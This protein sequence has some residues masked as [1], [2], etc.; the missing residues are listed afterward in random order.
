MLV[1]SLRTA[2]WRSTL[3]IRLKNKPSSRLFS[4]IAHEN[5][6]EHIRVRCK[7]S[8]DITVT[9][10]N[11]NKYPST[12]PLMIYLPPFGSLSSKLTP[13]I[14]LPLW[15]HEYPTAV[16]NYRWQPIPLTPEAEADQDNPS[17]KPHPLSWPTPIH[18]ILFGYT[19][20]SE[21]LVSPPFTEPPPSNS[22]SDLIPP[23]SIPSRP[24]YIY[25]SYL[26][27]T[28][29]TSLSLTESHSPKQTPSLNIR[30]LIAYNGIYNWTTFLPDHPLNKPRGGNHRLRNYIPFAYRT[31][32][33]P[34]YPDHH[35]PPSPAFTYLSTQLPLLFPSPSQLFD[36]FASPSLFFHT[37]PL[38]VPKDFTS[39]RSDLL[40]TIDPNSPLPDNLSTEDLF[41]AMPP[42][43]RGSLRYPPPESTLVIPPS[44]IIYDKD[45]TGFQYQAEEL[46]FYMKRSVYLYEG[47]EGKGFQYDLN[48]DMQRN[49]ERRRKYLEEKE[50]RVEMIGREIKKRKE[51][52]T[53][54]GLDERGEE[55]VRDWVGGMIL[56][57]RGGSQS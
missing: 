19:W 44:L 46:G 42:P 10:H 5:S 15:L 38:H 45:V 23:P 17:L 29:A 41:R 48:E 2:R 12:T 34:F 14:A 3:S 28:L 27:A 30:G 25:G 47:Y 8:G 32:S 50:R 43:D 37:P 18:D 6:V 1:L 40:K 55:F 54:W 56:E 24:A 49:E 9:L 31:R 35:S 33:H 4:A 21:N 7:S 20:L 22:D 36:S 11:I 57:E 53:K 16:I 13:Q 51:Q 26:G 39:T 52:S